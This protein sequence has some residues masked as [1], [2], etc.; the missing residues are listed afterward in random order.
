MFSTFFAVSLSLVFS[1]HSPSLSNTPA[2]N[3]TQLIKNNIIIVQ[4]YAG[5]DPHGSDPHGG[6]PHDEQHDGGLPANAA[7]TSRP[8]PADVY[9]G[10]APGSNSQQGLDNF[11]GK[12]GF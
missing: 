7:E 5:N 12:P 2:C 6:D 11:P 3:L 1:P 8:A 10:K 4:Q 9:G